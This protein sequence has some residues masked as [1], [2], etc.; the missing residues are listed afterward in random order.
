MKRSQGSKKSR[1]NKND[2]TAKRQACSAINRE[3]ASLVEQMLGR[4][5]TYERLAFDKELPDA[6]RQQ[7]SQVAAAL[8][9]AAKQMNDFL[10]DC[11]RRVNQTLANVVALAAATPSATAA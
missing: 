10:E 1:P 3:P 2:R 5:S 11:Q 4:A 8:R 9:E 6:D 7:A